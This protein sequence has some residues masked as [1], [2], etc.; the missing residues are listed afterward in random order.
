MKILEERYEEQ[1]GF[2]QCELRE[3]CGELLETAALIELITE[4]ADLD[5][6]QRRMF[7]DTLSRV[8]DRLGN[9]ESNVLAGDDE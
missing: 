1:D 2:D 6:P 9:A 7:G 5:T 8:L 4:Q 3:A